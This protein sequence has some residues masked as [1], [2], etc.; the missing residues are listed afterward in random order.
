M[1][2]LLALLLLVAIS[3]T[4]Q[5][6]DMKHFLFQALSSPNGSADGVLS[7]DKISD[8]F[9]QQ[10]HSTEPVKVSVSTIKRFKQDGCSRL[11]VTLGQDKVPLKTGGIAPFSLRY[12][13]NLCRDGSPPVE[14]MDMSKFRG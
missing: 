2:K 14:G 7:E 8:Y 6:D 10:T 5:A 11:V 4:A 3:A 9:K 1:R 12:E 13:L